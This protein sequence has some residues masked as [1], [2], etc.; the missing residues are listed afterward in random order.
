M[1]K[2]LAI[3]AQHLPLQMSQN[4]CVI[5]YKAQIYGIANEFN[6]HLCAMRYEV[7]VDTH[8]GKGVSY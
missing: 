8:S 2:G 7:L 5:L 4:L 3:T 1:I 6:Y